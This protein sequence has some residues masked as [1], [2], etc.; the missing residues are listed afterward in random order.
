VCYYYQGCYQSKIFLLIVNCSKVNDNPQQ[1]ERNDFVMLSQCLIIFVLDC[2][3]MTLCE[4]V[5]VN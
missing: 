3:L 4:R 5:D 2:Q 1:I